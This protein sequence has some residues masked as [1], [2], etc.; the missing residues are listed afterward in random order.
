MYVALFL[1]MDVLES[2]G[3]VLRCHIS[4]PLILICFNHQTGGRFNGLIRIATQD[5]CEILS[6]V[7]EKRPKLVIR[8]GMC[9]Q[10]CTVLHHEQIG[11][12]GWYLHDLSGD[13]SQPFSVHDTLGVQA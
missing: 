8:S 9:L 4:T 6:L 13:T 1:A 3:D 5:Q 10:L 2:A 12:G 7:R 11:R